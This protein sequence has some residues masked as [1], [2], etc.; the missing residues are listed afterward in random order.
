MEIPKLDDQDD[1]LV[2]LQNNNYSTQTILNYARDLC[3]FA[4]FL[5][6]RNTPFYESNKRYCAYKGYLIAGQHLKDLDKIRE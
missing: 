1:F 6:F 4:V 3:I 2:N 5:H